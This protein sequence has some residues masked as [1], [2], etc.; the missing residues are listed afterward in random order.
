MTNTSWK[1]EIKFPDYSCKYCG[2]VGWKVGFYLDS[3]GNPKYPFVCALCDKRTQHFAK[4]KAVEASG[5]EIHGIHP[6]TPP[7]ICEVCGAE[8]T[9]NHHW[10]P[11]ALFGIE[12][13]QWPKSYLCQPC[14]T[15]WHQIVTPNIS[16]VKKA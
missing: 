11:S 15:R 9:H 7:F 3:G 8:G 4:R 6:M 1:N 12:D 5:V 10:A 13:E 16:N 2:C 14:H